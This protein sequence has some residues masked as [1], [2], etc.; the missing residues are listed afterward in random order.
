VSHVTSAPARKIFE[1]CYEQQ[2]GRLPSPVAA[3][4]YDAVALVAEA[5]RAAGPNRAR[6]RDWVAKVKDFSGV[7]GTIS[8]DEQG[9]NTTRLRLVRLR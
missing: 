5:F 2:T 3:E 1:Q 9:N 6:V 4:A 8:F 7:S